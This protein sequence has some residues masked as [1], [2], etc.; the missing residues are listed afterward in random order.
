MKKQ[1]LL[2]GAILSGVSAFAQQAP[3]NTAPAGAGPSGQN[4]AQYW[5][6][7]GNN[8]FPVGNTNN[9]FGTLWNS[10]IY[11]QTFGVNRTKLNGSFTTS[12]NQYDIDGY[13]TFGNTNTTVNTSGYMLLGPNG[14]FQTEPTLNIY[15]NKGAYSL[16]HL[17]GTAPIQQNGYRPWM[18]TGIT[19]TDNQDMSYFGLRQIGTGL[20]WTETVMNW[21]DNQGGLEDDMCFRFTGAPTSSTTINMADMR[22]TVD[23]DGLHIARYTANG[24]YALGNTFGY[25]SAPGHPIGYV[26]PQ[27]LFHMSYD[28]QTGAANEAYGF[29][30]VTYRN[31][32]AM[33]GSGELETDG[34]RLG[35]DNE[36][37]GTGPYQHL[38][39]Y[40]RWQEASSFVIQT[41]DNASPNIQANE[42]MRITSIGALALNYP[43]SSYIG[44]TIP[45]QVTRIGVSHNGS[46]ALSR[47]MSLMHLGYNI[48]STFGGLTLQQGYRS[49]MDLGMLVSNSTDNIWIG[50]KPRVGTATNTN[51]ELDAVISWGNDAEYASTSAG[52]DVMSFIYTAD[53]I[54]PIDSSAATTQNGLEVMRMYPGKDVIYSNNDSIYGRVGIGDFTFT[55]VNEQ[56]THKLDV[57]GNGRFRYLPD[58]LYLA[59]T[60]V[61]KIVMVDELGV[62]RW[63]DAVPSSFGAICSDTVNGKLTDDTKLDLNN[64][65]LYFTR[66]DTIGSNLVGIGYD[67]GEAMKAKLNTFSKNELWSGSFYVDGNSPLDPNFQGGVESV[68][69]STKTLNATAIRGYVN[70]NS[71]GPM[72]SQIGVEGEVTGLDVKE[73]VGVKGISTVISPNSAAIG[74]RF[75]SNGSAAGRAV[76]AQNRTVQT[77]GVGSGFGIGGDF[78]SITTLGQSVNSNTGVTG[79]ANGLSQNNTGVRGLSSGNGVINIGVYGLAIGGTLKR[80]GYFNGDVEIINGLL[81]SDQQFKTNVVPVESALKIVSNLNPKS[82]Y[83]DTVNFDSFNFG[84]EK[85]YG[86]IAQDVESVLPELVHNSI[87][88]GKYDSLGNLIGSPTTYKSLNY[89]AIIPINTQA[90]KELNVKVDKATL[91]DQTIKTN[92]QDLAGSLDKVLE[93]R[94]VTY[95]WNGVNHPNLQ[96]DSVLHI[97]FIAQEINAIDP[98]LTFIDEDT[99]MH[100]EYDKVVPILAE[101]IQELNGQVVSQDSIIEVLT[102]ENVAQQAQIEDLNDRLTQLENCLSGILPFLCQM[103]NSSIQPTQQEVQ[104]QLRTAINVNLSN[105]NAIVLNQ[106]VPNPFAES[107]TITYSVPSSVQKAQIHFYDGTGKL[108]N[109]VD[110]TERGNGQLNVFANDLSSGVYTYSLVADGQV[111]STKRMVKE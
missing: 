90:I 83:F 53:P 70:Q 19:F 3:T 67:C 46:T 88:P 64:H 37:A 18:K 22:S 73:A 23:L 107:T 52:I 84:S 102:N 44:Q 15:N 56:P 41:E 25:T 58:S 57:V 99:L 78:S 66:N 1:F 39:G 76:Q 42:R 82:Y 74:G 6:R 104:E 98:L 54:S 36:I 51:N 85:Q 97:G 29:M 62:L 63:A 16:L 75:L 48:G 65:N 21:S 27:S 105:K 71:Y 108:I 45:S 26:A 31:A 69:D 4:S 79:H 20:D 59:D 33:V 32:V 86:F 14:T 109:S 106:N 103:N 100:V 94:G 11:T 110:I 77:A 101:A 38:D 55:G 81:I 30:Q 89:N 9:I 96:L 91:S 87:N 60:L 35:I 12:A 8:N 80:A 68:I 93:M 5:S 24:R 13:T 49:W 2:F 50:L 95:E 10:P 40:L 111:V 61:K 72:V 34:L 28:R 17:N 7:A 92:V 47:P 43:P